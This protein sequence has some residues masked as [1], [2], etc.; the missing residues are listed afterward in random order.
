MHTLKSLEELT[1]KTSDIVDILPKRMADF[2][3]MEARRVRY[4]RQLLRMNRQLLNTKGRSVHLPARGSVIAVRVSEAYEPTTRDVAWSTV[5]VTPF[6]LG[7]ALHVTQESIDGSEIDVINGSIEESGIALAVR[8]DDEIFNELLGR[9]PDPGVSSGIWSWTA[10][11]D[12]FVGD[13][14][15]T[16]YTLDH[17]PVIEM[18]EV[19]V[20]AV[21]STAFTV[22]YYDG[23]LEFT[24]AP[25]SGH[26]IIVNYWYSERTS[27]LRANTAATFKYE[28]VIASK[29]NMRSNKLYGNVMVMH[30]DEY[31]DILLDS[32]FV[33]SSQYGSREPILNG[34]V[35]QI[36]GLKVLVTTAIP[37][38]T[39][40]YLMTQRAGWYVL[41][42]NI[43]VKRKEAQ[44]TD[45]YKFYFYFEFAP[46]VTDENAVVLTVNHAANAADIA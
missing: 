9:Q 2:V 41:K 3:E 26:A 27:Y 30:P 28:D 24:A 13:G 29:T 8:E 31:A 4:G 20:N 6:K 7:I 11:A 25:T 38:G 10:Q 42:R 44:E 33:D 17:G 16:K 12:N 21:A 18:S 36:A 14:A 15:T 34:E 32:R 43:D 39:V 22:D 19:T 46:R 1:L 40:L 23:E 5:E 37:S 35:G 45:S